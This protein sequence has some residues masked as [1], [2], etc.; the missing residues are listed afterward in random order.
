MKYFILGYA[1]V[2]TPSKACFRALD[3][4]KFEIFWGSAPVTTGIGLQ[5]LPRTTSCIDACYARNVPAGP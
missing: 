3:S 1:S 5:H 4:M 2:L